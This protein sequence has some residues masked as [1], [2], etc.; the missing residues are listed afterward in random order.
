MP[1]SASPACGP[2][3]CHT[4]LTSPVPCVSKGV[5]APPPGEGSGL[6]EPIP[7]PSCGHATGSREV[8]LPHILN[9]PGAR[10]TILSSSAWGICPLKLGPLVAAHSDA[11]V[12]V[13]EV[14]ERK[15]FL[16]PSLGPFCPPPVISQGDSHS[17]DPK[18][19]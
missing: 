16:Y 1:A 10:G 19:R 6:G 18:G 8:F 2:S 3:S 4:N 17:S 7:F 5:A 12:L 11:K 9:P 14:S 15:E 13:T